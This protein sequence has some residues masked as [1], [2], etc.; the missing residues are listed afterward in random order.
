MNVLELIKDASRRLCCRLKSS[1]VM[2]PRTT[3]NT[4]RL[5]S[6]RY[7]DEI[8]LKRWKAQTKTNLRL[9]GI[10]SIIDRTG[11]SELPARIITV[12]FM[13]EKAELSSSA[14]NFV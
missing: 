7:V 9:N 13:N 10:L 12:S 6:K 8:L 2:T 1:V 11:A 5:S 14:S 4:V 3:V